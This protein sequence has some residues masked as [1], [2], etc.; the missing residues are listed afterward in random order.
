M[1]DK[2]TRVNNNAIYFKT[3]KKIQKTKLSELKTDIILVI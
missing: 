1:A 2:Y 3:C